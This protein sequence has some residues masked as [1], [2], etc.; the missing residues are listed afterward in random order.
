MG[1]S[2]KMKERGIFVCK[3]KLISTFITP[4]KNVM[5]LHEQWILL[6]FH[7]FCSINTTED[8]TQKECEESVFILVLSEGGTG[9]DLKGVSWR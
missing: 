9:N 7:F 1:L 3:K 6:S 4:F 2:G 5:L 8:K